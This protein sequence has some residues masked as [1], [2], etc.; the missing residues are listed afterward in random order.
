[1]T[2][3]GRQD[4]TPL[5]LE[6]LAFKAIITNDEIPD[7]TPESLTEPLMKQWETLINMEA[8]YRIM[9]TTINIM[10]ASGMSSTKT[11]ASGWTSTK[12]GLL[13]RAK[14]Y[15]E[16]LPDCFE[17]ITVQWAEYYIEPI[18]L[19]GGIEI[20]SRRDDPIFFDWD[21]ENDD[22]NYVGNYFT[23]VYYKDGKVIKEKWF[24]EN[25]N[26]YLA[27]PPPVEPWLL[28]RDA[29]GLSEDGSLIW[30]IT[31]Y[32]RGGM[33]QEDFIMMWTGRACRVTY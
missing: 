10:D 11:D 12:F 13:D 19:Q 18:G 3:M 5:T 15:A 32:I 28:S 1:M 31:K 29:I 4:M 24:T 22:F 16:L 25:Q 7:P 33:D 20:S 23:R 14:H 9:F 17:S 21:D 8:D 6:A 27:Q 26:P 2:A 30:H